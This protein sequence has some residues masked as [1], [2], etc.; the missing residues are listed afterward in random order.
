MKK[1]TKRLFAALLA[2]TSLLLIS[3][4]PSTLP[5]DRSHTSLNQDFRIQSVIVHYT[6]IDDAQ[7]LEELTRPESRVSAHYLLSREER[8]GQPI[9]YALVPESQRAWHAGISHLI[10][11]S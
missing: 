7:S 11:F 6:Q 2:A 5:I 10:L 9:V 4:Q 3:C 8:D 1:S